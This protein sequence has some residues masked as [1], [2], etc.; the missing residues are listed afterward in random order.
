M[1]KHG[2]V[3]KLLADLRSAQKTLEALNKDL[4]RA[5]IAGSDDVQPL[6]AVVE[7]QYELIMHTTQELHEALRAA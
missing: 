5:N 1:T 7:R 3:L 2:R 6:R 4:L